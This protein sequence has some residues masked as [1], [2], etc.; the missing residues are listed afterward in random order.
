MASSCCK[1]F[2][3]MLLLGPAVV[4]GCVARIG[5]VPVFVDALPETFNLDVADAIRK[6]S[7]RTKAIIPVHLFG[8][9]ADLEL[10]PLA[11]DVR[12]VFDRA[13]RTLEDAGARLV[14]VALPEAELVYPTFRTIQGAEAL[15]T[16][17]RAGLYPARRDEYGEDVLGR[18]D[19]AT[20]ITGSVSARASSGSFA[21]AT[22]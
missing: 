17:R 14:D 12:A 10:V 19:A 22:C 9:C 6:I 1:S 11:P 5:A 13:V 18:L 15:D 2:P 3:W 7:P 20:E 21:R 4:A 8:L 16:H